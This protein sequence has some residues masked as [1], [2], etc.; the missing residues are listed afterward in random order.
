MVLPKGIFQ[1]EPCKRGLGKRIE[2]KGPF[3]QGLPK[4]LCKKHLAKGLGAKTI[5][6]RGWVSFPGIKVA[7]QWVMIQGEHPP[8]QTAGIKTI[9][10]QNDDTSS[11]L[12]HFPVWALAASPSGCGSPGNSHGTSS[13]WQGET[14]GAPEAAHTPH[15]NRERG[16]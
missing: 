11:L 14:R 6:Q 1:K 10:S 15:P 5:L 2:P 8:M 16:M 12:K 7:R 3:K 9:S 4:R 13:L